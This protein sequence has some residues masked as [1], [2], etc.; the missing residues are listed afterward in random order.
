[1]SGRWWAFSARTISVRA[2]PVATRRRRRSVSLQAVAIA[3]RGMWRTVPVSVRPGTAPASAESLP[4]PA[5]VEGVEFRKLFLV[6]NL[7]DLRA[8]IL[9]EFAYRVTAFPR[10]ALRA[11]L[12]AAAARLP[13][14]PHFTHLAREY[15]PQRL[16]LFVGQPE[17]FRQ[18]REP[19]LDPLLHLLRAMF[20]ILGLRSGGEEQ[21]ERQRG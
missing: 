11:A 2:E 6:E 7:P 19:F 17:V 5:L 16:D 12:G 9:H 13:E 1:M 14:L 15:R 21:R 18:T 8:R 3:A 10:T 20:A 4:I